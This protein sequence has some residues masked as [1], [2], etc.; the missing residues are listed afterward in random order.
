MMVI[1]NDINYN[2]ARLYNVFCESDNIE[3]YTIQ[4]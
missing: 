1:D 2:K 3:K 4:S